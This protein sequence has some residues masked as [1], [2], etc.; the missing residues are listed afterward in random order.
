MRAFLRGH[1]EVVQLL[2]VESAK[3]GDDHERRCECRR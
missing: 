3:E 2:I 1:I